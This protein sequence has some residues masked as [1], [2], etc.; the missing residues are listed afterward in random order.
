MAYVV[1]VNH[2]NNKA[3]VHNSMCGK[4][5]SRRRDESHN[6]YWTQE[7]SNNVNLRHSFTDIHKWISSCKIE[8]V[9]SVGTKFTALA[10]ITKRGAH[11]VKPVIRFFQRGTEYVRAYE[12]CWGHYYNCN[13]TR[14]GMYCQALDSYIKK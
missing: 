13:R 3:I 4:Y 7:F 9:T 11:E 5:Q 14:I 10:D 12:C 1:Y 6:G 2:P 8:L